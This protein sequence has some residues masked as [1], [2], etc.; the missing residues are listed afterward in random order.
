MK[1]EDVSVVSLLFGVL[2]TGLGLW[3]LVDS[4][5]WGRLDLG[6]VWPALLVVAGVAVLIAARSR[7]RVG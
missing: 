3:F 1:T 5:G 4:L 2:F 7:L 6:L